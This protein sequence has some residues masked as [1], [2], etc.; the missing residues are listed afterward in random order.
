M[1]NVTDH[2]GTFWNPFT[3]SC[4]RAPHFLQ[5]IIDRRP[6]PWLQGKTLLL[7]GDSVDRNNGRFFCEW[8]NSTNVRIT[9]FTNLSASA[10]EEGL[11]EHYRVLTQPRVCR[12]DDYDFEIITFFHYGVEESDIWNDHHTYIPPGILE[13]RINNLLKPM[14]ENYHRKPDMIIL[15]SGTPHLKLFVCGV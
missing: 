9:S 3:P 1:I 10:N 12:I 8:A 6:L 2:N 13:L 4:Q 5:D 14:F 11:E 7:V 15:N